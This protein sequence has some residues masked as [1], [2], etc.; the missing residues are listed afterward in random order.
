MLKRKTGI[1]LLTLLFVTGLAGT[2]SDNTITKSERKKAVKLMKD[3]YK[4]ALH[5]LKGLSEQ[6]LNY[7]T[8]PNRWSVKECFFHISKTE[9]TLWS[10]FEKAMKE[11]ANPEKRKE[12]KFTDDQII[13]MVE[14]RSHKAKAPTSLQPE[15]TGYTSLA[16]AIEDF[17][18]NRT[19]HIKYMKH[20]TEDLRN[21]VIQL[22]FGSVDCYQFYL[23]MA[24]HSNR[25][26][27]QMNEVKADSGF[28][29]E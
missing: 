4:D 12:I 17:K 8:D 1:L 29:E 22:P 11:P 15:N 25:H 2:T 24:G 9:N 19:N 28:P 20:T 18:L 14:D 3:T 6:Q 16:E 10:N 21:H 26:T 13:K 27:Q 5:S 7:R 23:F